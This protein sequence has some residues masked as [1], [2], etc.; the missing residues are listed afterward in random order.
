MNDFNIQVGKNGNLLF[1]GTA[2][3][4][5]ANDLK[6]KVGA[7]A[8]LTAVSVYQSASSNFNIT[9]ATNFFSASGNTNIS[10]GGNILESASEIHMNGPLAATATSA[11]AATDLALP[12]YSLPSTSKSAGWSAGNF[13]KSTDVQSIMQR[14][15][16]HEPWSQHENTNPSLYTAVSTDTVAGATGAVPTA[17]KQFPLIN[18]DQ[19]KDWTQ[20]G[21]FMNKVISVAEQLNCNYLDLF[22]CMAFE[23]GRTFNPSLV[24]SIG[25]TGLIQFI[26]STAKSLGTTTI[27]LAGLTRTA[28]MD[29]VLK[30]FKSGPIAKVAKPSLADLYMAILW[31]AAVGKPMDYHLFEAGT[32]AYQQNPLDTGKKGYVSKADAASKV[33]SQLPYLKDLFSKFVKSGTGV[34]ITDGSGAPVKSGQ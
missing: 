16:M 26:P 12:I 27:E 25:A 11:K 14:V 29:W 13:Y 30:Y 34:I 28:Q 33:T 19:P 3:L 22:A 1:G 10:S 6:L 24:N 20:D 7:D 8:H 17:G 23:T 21:K 5:V 9:A 18:P 2:D 15:P 31:P 4:S 32:K